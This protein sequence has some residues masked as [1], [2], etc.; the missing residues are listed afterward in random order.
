MAVSK[1]S[2]EVDE[3]FRNET[4]T[5]RPKR[6][7]HRFQHHTELKRTVLPAVFA[8]ASLKVFDGD[9]NLLDFCP[10]NEPAWRQGTTMPNTREMVQDLRRW[11]DQYSSSSAANAVLPAF[12]RHLAGRFIYFNNKAEVL[13]PGCCHALLLICST[14]LL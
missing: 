2:S 12:Q 4:V 13:Q 10:T 7:W 8:G 11:A 6:W 14:F 5:V 3:W 1:V 9:F